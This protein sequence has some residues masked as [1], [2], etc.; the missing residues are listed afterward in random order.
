MV[1]EAIEVRRIVVAAPEGAF[2]LAGLGRVT[3]VRHHLAR[4][5]HLQVAGGL[6]KL[7]VGLLQREAAALVVERP[8]RVAVQVAEAFAAHAE[9]RGTAESRNADVVTSRL[10]CGEVHLTDL[11]AAVA[12]RIG[13]V[14]HGACQRH[15]PA[16]FV[17]RLEPVEARIIH[18]AQVGR[19]P[20]QVGVAPRSPAAVGHL[21]DL[22]HGGRCARRVVGE[23]QFGTQRCLDAG[24]VHSIRTPGCQRSRQRQVEGVPVE[25]ILAV[26]ADVAVP[27]FVT[28]APHGGRMQSLRIRGIVGAGYRENLRPLR[29]GFGSRVRA[30]GGAGQGRVDRDGQQVGPDQFH[31][32]ESFDVAFGQRRGIDCRAFR[33]DLAFEVALRRRGWI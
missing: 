1:G 11:F 27:E 18:G 15:A 7:R 6:D 25:E 2:R 19:P 24:H 16:G 32:T 12:R 17:D 30:G 10:Q 5:V 13:P 29:G 31:G 28:V 3:V 9:T 22:E 20:A 14:L 26:G 8:L 33:R 21:V 23:R 4:R